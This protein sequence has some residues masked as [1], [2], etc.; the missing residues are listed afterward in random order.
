[1]RTKPLV[2]EKLWYGPRDY[3]W[4]WEPE[5]REGEIVGVVLITLA[6]VAG[7]LSIWWPRP[8]FLGLLGSFVALTAVGFLKGTVPVVQPSA[9]NTNSCETRTGRSTSTFGNSRSEL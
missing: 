7:L 4:G 5:C 1:M 9:A 3:G 2:G 6:V 8:G